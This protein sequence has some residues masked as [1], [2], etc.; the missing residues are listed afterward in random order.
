MTGVGMVCRQFM[1]SQNSDPF[2]VGGAEYLI[3]F[4]PVWV[5]GDDREGK[6]DFYH[7]YYGTLAMFQQGGES[8][9]KWNAALKPV[10]LDHQRKGGP[11]DGSAADVDGSWDP[12]GHSG[13]C[14]GRVFQTA[15]GAL[16]LEVYYRYLPMYAK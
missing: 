10:L 3:Q 6:R 15:V 5:P 4:P 13:G 8:W 16:S 12:W 1:G 7:I 9:S 2:V 14:G 11:L